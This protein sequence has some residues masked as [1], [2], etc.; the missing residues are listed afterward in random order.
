MRLASRH[1]IAYAIL[2]PLAGRLFILLDLITKPLI[3]KKFSEAA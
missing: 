1:N 2:S 3:P